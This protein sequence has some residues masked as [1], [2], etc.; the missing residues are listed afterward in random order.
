MYEFLG[1]YQEKPG[2]NI[3]GN[4]S[5]GGSGNGFN[6]PMGGEKRWLFG[7]FCLRVGWMFLKIFCDTLVNLQT[8]VRERSCKKLLHNFPGLF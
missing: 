8:A 7:K 3:G 4:R 5:D 2:R 1:R 6:G